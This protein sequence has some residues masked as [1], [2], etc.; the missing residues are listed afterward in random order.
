[1]KTDPNFEPTFHPRLRGIAF[2]MM[3]KEDQAHCKVRVIVTLHALAEMD[4]TS[5]D[6]ETTA[7]EC[8][9]RFR[10]RIEAAASIKF[11][12]LGPRVEEFE[13]LP[14]FLLMTGDKI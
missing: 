1:M 8:F 3:S 2:R 12:L 9:K 13:G 14:T 5:V 4:R 11:G 10:G 6:N 7:L